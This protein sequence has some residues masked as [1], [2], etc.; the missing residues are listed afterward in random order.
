MLAPL[1][2]ILGAFFPLGICRAVAVHEDLVPWAWGINGCAPVTA[3]V[4]AVL[5]AMSYGFEPVWV[6]SVA[7]H[8][9]GVAVLLLTG[10]STETECRRVAD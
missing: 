2:L 4:L 5:L 6:L 8:A 3:T 9:A 1:G 7:I 10:H